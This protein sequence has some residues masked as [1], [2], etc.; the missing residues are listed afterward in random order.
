[1][2]TIPV[3]PKELGKNARTCDIG[4]VPGLPLFYMSDFSIMG[5]QVTPYE[6][7]I[8]LLKDKAYRVNVHSAGAK[9]MVDTLDDVKEVFRRFQK[10]EIRY[11]LSD[12]A[13][14]FYQG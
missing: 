14:A 3:V 1:M 7:A 4:T 10:A 12:L 8:R 6:K 13:I 9:L 2:L 11:D 5:L